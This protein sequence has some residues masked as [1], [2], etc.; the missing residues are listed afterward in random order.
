MLLFTIGL[1]PQVIKIADS[2]LQSDDVIEAVLKANN[3]TLLPY[4]EDLA[5]FTERYQKKK[6]LM[7][8][9][10]FP[11][12]LCDCEC[13]HRTV[14]CRKCL[15]YVCPYLAKKE[16]V[17]DGTWQKE[18]FQCC[19]C[20]EDMRVYVKKWEAKIAAKKTQNK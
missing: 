11:E 20:V 7:S 1:D 9:V 19:D 18:R 8:E 4:V 15:K 5:G 10:W 13:G 16:I 2:V 14:H 3:K 6:F 17:M 12:T